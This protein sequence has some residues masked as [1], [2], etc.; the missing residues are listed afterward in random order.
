M[1]AFV[2]ILGVFIIFVLAYRIYGKILGS[3]WDVDGKRPTPALTQTD[4]VD[5]IPAKN[6]LV[7]F[8][9][10]FSSIAGAGPIVGPIMA[11]LIWGW[12]PALA[13]VVLG[14]IFLG[15]IH[16]YGSLMISIREKGSSVGDIASSVIS[17]KAK[18]IFS[19]FLWLTL[20][21]IVAVFAYLAADT[22]SEQG[23]IV[24]PS[25]GLIP[26][27]MGVG[28]A[29][30]R[31]KYPLVPVTILGLSALAGLVFLGNILPINLPG[32]ERNF[33][34]ITLLIYCFFASVL[35]VNYLLQPRD[36]LSSFLLFAGITLGV[37]GIFVTQPMTKTPAFIS[38]DSAQGFLWPMM[39]ITV[40]CGAISGFHSLIS[41]GTTSKQI[42]NEN[43]AKKIGFGGMLM[44]GF[45]ATLVI[46]IFASGFSLA[47]FYAHRTINTNPITLFGEGFGHATKSF[48]GPWGNFIALFILNAFILTTLDSATRIA[49]YITE[50]IA[51]IKNRFLSTLT[52]VVLA[53]ALALAKDTTHLPLWKKIWPI[54]GASNQL[55]GALA[56]IVVTCWL[57]QRKKTGF[58]Y[59]LIPAIFMLIT[60][61]TALAIKLPAHW[62]NQ[63]FLLVF[64][65]T[66]LIISALMLLTEVFTIFNQRRR[67]G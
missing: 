35:P 58:F 19:I 43:D 51:P 10:H 5:Y 14:S 45:L 7:L 42:A 11:C 30:Y 60:S 25:L 61:L 24:I 15:S 33:W 9:H 63:E 49:R 21:L 64:I 41:S 47:E 34:I 52:V 48:L 2:L 32:Q 53:G 59:A 66:I 3:L 54:F 56:L 39:F 57:L 28:V 55:V 26:I 22:F 29:L 16:D 17:R 31:L 12:A 4:G 23:E 36:Y 38:A 18:L 46:A 27:A 13:W 67:H 65:S 62:R 1:N 50:E 44:E 8:G 40:A 6:I 37:V 20:I